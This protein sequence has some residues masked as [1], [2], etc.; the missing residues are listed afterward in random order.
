MK[1]QM[2]SP[3]AVSLDKNKKVSD[4]LPLVSHH[5]PGPASSERVGVEPPFDHQLFWSASNNPFGFARVI[6]VLYSCICA[7]LFVF[8]FI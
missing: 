2:S 7:Y 6:F 3:A 1:E 8:Y 4:K 5:S